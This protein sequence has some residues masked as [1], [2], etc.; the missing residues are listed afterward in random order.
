MGFEQG[1]KNNSPVDCCLAA[2]TSQRRGD[3]EVSAETKSPPLRQNKKP[4]KKGGLFCFQFSA[5]VVGDLSFKVSF[6]ST[7]VISAATITQRTIAGISLES[8]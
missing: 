5:T 4:T 1:V 8:I 7:G 6:K 2:A 3:R